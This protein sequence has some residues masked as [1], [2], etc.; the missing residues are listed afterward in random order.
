ME[1]KP[2]H[3]NGTEIEPPSDEERK[4]IF[5]KFFGS[6][7]SRSDKPQADSAHNKQGKLNV[8][9]SPKIGGVMELFLHPCVIRSSA[10]TKKLSNFSLR[11]YKLVKRIHHAL[12]DEGC[13]DM[14]SRAT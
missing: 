7:N 4:N 10:L 1:W 14:F 8:C 3:I 13:C 11:E 2:T 6:E 12:P 9:V 5:N